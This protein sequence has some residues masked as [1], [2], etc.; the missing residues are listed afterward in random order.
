MKR[1]CISCF[2]VLA[3]VTTPV[4]AAQTD[5]V[6]DP[7]YQA[8]L[9]KIETNAEEG[10]RFAL[11]W[12]TDGGGAPAI[13]CAAVAD[14]ALDLPKV[15]ASRL[16]P[17]ADKTATQDPALAAKLYIQI[18]EAWSIAGREAEALAA[19]EKAYANAPEAT[20]TELLAAPVFAELGRW[21]R[22]QRAL[23]KVE[24]QQPLSADALVLRARAKMNLSD[25]ES[26]AQ[27]VQKALN[28]APDHIAGLVLRGELAQAGHIIAIY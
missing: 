23:D 6:I 24:N 28:M 26:A 18:A 3:L 25:P 22:V 17:L 7:D 8:C 20:E 14:L 1:I 4:T 15:A 21:G 13:H 9:T 2:T 19:L 27:D 11:R 10:R 12:V 5:M 16:Q